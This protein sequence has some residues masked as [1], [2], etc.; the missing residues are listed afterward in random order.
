MEMFKRPLP[1]S[2]CLINYSKYQMFNARDLTWLKKT[3]TTK[4]NIIETKQCPYKSKKENMR[5]NNLD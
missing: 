4:R 2:I 5:I 3:T 1:M